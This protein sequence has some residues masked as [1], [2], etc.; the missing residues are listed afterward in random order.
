MELFNIKNNKVE[1]IDLKPF[2]LEK[3]IQSLVEQNIETFF[4]LEFVSSEYSIGN[5]RLDSLCFNPESK[6]FVIIEYKKGSSYSVIDQGFS[7]LSLMVNNKSDFIIEYNEKLGKNLRRNDIDWS[8]SRIIFVSPAFNTYQKNSVNFK[9]LPFE[10]WEIKRY[11]N[12]TVTM[13]KFEASSQESIDSLD[14]IKN[15]TIIKKVTNEIKVIGEEEH[16]SKSEPILIEKWEELKEKF[17]AFENTEIIS[18]KSYVS[19][20]INKINIA[21][22]SFRKQVINIDII[23]GV[24][25][26]D[27]TKSKNYF[28]LDDPKQISKNTT[29]KWNDGNI[30]SK[31][32]IKITKNTDTDYLMFLIKQKYK[33][34]VK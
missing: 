9:N 33:N 17:S 7:Y 6:S 1:S 5:F 31:Y 34:L 27:N 10:L 8:Q 21:S 15:E 29:W 19:L 12:Q 4:Q 18:K 14:N 11:S 23:R 22:F 13:N 32:K 30:G 25:K 3:E 2:K 26:T 20:M 16:I 28:T 24:L